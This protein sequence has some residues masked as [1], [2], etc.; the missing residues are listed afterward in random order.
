M[1]CCFLNSKAKTTKSGN[2]LPPPPANLTFKSIALGFGIQNY[3]CAQQGGNS[4]AKG[5]LAMLY[6]ITDLYPGRGPSSLSQSDFENLTTKA[7]EN[8]PVPLNFSKSAEDRVDPNFPGASVA[9]PFPQDADLNVCGSKPL[10]FM[11]HHFFNGC[12]VPTFVSRDGAIN[13]SVNLL[14]GVDAPKKEGTETVKWLAL[15]S[16]D[17]SQFVYRPL[18]AGGVSHGC[19]NGTGDDSTAYTATYWFYI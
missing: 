17:D 6:N 4:T 1:K 5:A 8:Y 11:G 18:T 16:K 12:G 7:L 2:G 10:P 9:E 19:K 14:Q 13:M 15:K 3:T